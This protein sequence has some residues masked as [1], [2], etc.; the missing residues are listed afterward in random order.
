MTESFVLHVVL[1]L[2]ED[3]LRL[4]GAVGSMHQSFLRGEPV[5]CLL[6]VLHKALV[7]S[8]LPHRILTLIAFSP[9]RAPLAV[10]CPVDTCLGVVSTIRLVVAGADT[11]HVLA[12]RADVVIVLLVVIEVLYPED[13]VL[14]RLLLLFV[15]VVEFHVCFNPVGFHI[16]VILLAAV[17]RIG[18][19][20]L[21]Q[22]V[23]A[24]GER[25]EEGN[26]RAGVIGIGDDVQSCKL[27]I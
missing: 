18:T 20:F 24:V 4:Y 10:F 8:Y 9:E 16:C 25:G 6:L 12:H 26:H 11:Y 17:A 15:E 1:H 23:V 3:G 19:P 2:S 14:K 22:T 13:V 7:G 27:L 5:P 21:G